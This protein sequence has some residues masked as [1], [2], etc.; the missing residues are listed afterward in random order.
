MKF[1]KISKSEL[2]DMWGQYIQDLRV[3]V[4]DFDWYWY[5]PKFTKRGI[6]QGAKLVGFV[7]TQ[8]HEVSEF[9]ISPE[10][11]RKRFG[12]Q[13]VQMLSEELGE[14]RYYVLDRNK[15][16]QA[17]WETATPNRYLMATDGRGK[18]Y[19]NPKTDRGSG[20]RKHYARTEKGKT[21][22]TPADSGRTLF[23]QIRLF[24]DVFVTA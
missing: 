17:L 23:Q 1:G 6:Y 2:H 7:I 20:D 4:D 13:A 21:E 5:N 16:G 11:R 3:Y 18:W 19:G 22:E 10:H 12:L 8:S 15:S 14:Y 9:Y 24:P